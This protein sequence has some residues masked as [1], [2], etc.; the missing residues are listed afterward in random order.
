MNSVVNIDNGKD[1]TVRQLMAPLVPFLADPEVTELEITGAGGLFAKAKGRR[2]WHEIPRLTL[3]DLY[4]FAN[5]VAVFNGVSLRPILS[6]VMPDGERAQ[7]VTPPACID[8]TLA[9]NIRKHSTRAFS[10]AEMESQGVF[11][12]VTDT[13]FN[14]PTPAEIQEM[15][16]RTDMTRLDGEEAELLQLKQEGRWREFLMKAV[17]YK[18][19]IIIAGKTGSGKT[20]FARS[21]TQVIPVDERVVTIEDVHE[22]KL[23]NHA[24]KVHLLYGTG[25]GR[26][27]SREALE[28]CMRLSMDRILLAELRGE[29]ALTYVNSLNTGHPGSITTT[30]A[31]NAIDTYSRVADLVKTSA[32]GRDIGAD[33]IKD[34]LYKTLHVVVFYKDMRVH[35]IFY[36]PVFAKAP[37]TA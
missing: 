7:I 19:N 26:I 28:A 30:H 20:T 25:P 3:A 1:A 37:R 21:L 18:R 5:A 2:V 23:D 11:E 33:V 24:N 34:M 16:H 4:A 12:T 29:E 13:S 17:E 22:L 8:G 10:L 36:D 31:N 27:S 6:V 9:I 35:Q 14:Q 15:Q 32:T